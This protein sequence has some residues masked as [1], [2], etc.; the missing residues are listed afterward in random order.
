[1]I[2]YS[3]RTIFPINVFKQL[4]QRLS[5]LKCIKH[6]RGQTLL[7]NNKCIVWS[8]FRPKIQS[9]VVIFLT[10]KW[11]GICD[12]SI[13]GVTNINFQGW[14]HVSTLWVWSLINDHGPVMWFV[15]DRREWNLP[16]FRVGLFA[17]PSPHHVPDVVDN[18]SL[19]SQ[20]NY[21]WRVGI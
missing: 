4:T 20:G 8:G 16:T 3:N 21:G 11:S 14:Y 5:D 9:R 7:W 18:L 19:L 15:Q 10:V 2:E 13:P 6:D 12:K 1:M 17:A